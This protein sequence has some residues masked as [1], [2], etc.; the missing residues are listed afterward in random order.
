[1]WLK[2]VRLKWQWNTCLVGILLAIH[3]LLLGI[4][5]ESSF[6]TRDEVAHLPAGIAHWQLD[7]FSLYSVNPPLWRM[8]AVLPVLPLDPEMG[9]VSIS[10]EPGARSEW[11]AARDFAENN[12]ARY[13]TM[14]RLSRLAGILW[15][16]L[17]A[18]LIYV[19]SRRLYGPVAALLGL[20]LWCFDPNVLG[21][22]PLLTPDMPLTVAVFG[23]TLVFWQC[24]RRPTWAGALLC[25]LVLGLAQLTKFTA[26]LLYFIW[27]LL[28]LFRE[29]ARYRSA[30]WDLWP[31]YLLSV[32]GRAFLIG[33][34]SIIVVNLGYNF[35]ASFHRVKDFRFIS[36]TL[37]TDGEHN[38]HSGNRF[39]DDWLGDVP[40]PLPADFVQGIDLQHFEFEKES[41]KSYLNGEIRTRGWWYYYLYAVLYKAPLGTVALVVWA[42][43]LTLARW[44]LSRVPFPQ[45]N[46]GASRVD[47]FFLWL[48]PVFLFVFISSQTGFN[49]HFRYVLP[50]F[51]FLYVAV[52]QVG[53]YWQG[54]FERSC[55][56]LSG[57]AK[58]RLAVCVLGGGLLLW[59]VSSSLSIF[60]HSMSYFNELA[61]GPD[62]G[63][64]HLI[65]SNI[66]WGQDM[67]F[68]KEWI[69][70]HPEA[71][72]FFIAYHNFIDYRDITKMDFPEPPAA[73]EPGYFAVD[74][75]KLTL[76]PYT[77][78]QRFQPN[79]KAGYSIF[80]Y[81]ITPEEA[82]VARRDLGYPP[83]PAEVARKR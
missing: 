37:R 80:I 49:R 4:A 44:P 36:K 74:V 34:T 24:G 64:R 14:M 11:Q 33:A 83:L 22:A 70:K 27:P 20:T 12:S 42:A 45:K 38:Q 48:P 40:I 21:H 1:M 41:K 3:A 58:P 19:W 52:S 10:N 17:C 51:P 82:A 46:E 23:A 30:A 7:T 55:E 76:G 31:R 66:D 25:G 68:L 8:L 2:R 50:I 13:W 53:L 47:E 67:W 39:Q 15:S 43:V 62:N 32:A 81:H 18:F 29:V 26:L 5:V 56:G 59:S 75:H 61:G 79:A 63:Q 78:F 9:G 65:D 77:Y 6:P 54:V 69:D 35:D 73:P 71:K 28:W 60:P 72:P 57:F 16:L